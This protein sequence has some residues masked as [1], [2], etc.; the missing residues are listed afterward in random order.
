MVYSIFLQMFGAE[1]NYRT[2]FFSRKT[3]RSSVFK[4]SA[5]HAANFVGGYRFTQKIKHV[6]PTG[7]RAPSFPPRSETLFRQCVCE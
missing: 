5:K 2:I 6:A 7:W 4:F 3:N 1:Q